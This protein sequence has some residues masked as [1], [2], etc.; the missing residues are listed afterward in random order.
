MRSFSFFVARRY[1][2]SKKSHHAIN[3]ISAISVIGV[4]FATL[5][6]VCTLSV[7]N[8]F[9]ELVASCFTAFDPQLKV[10]PLSGKTVSANDS[11]LLSLRRHPMVDV[12]SES[13][14]EHALIAFGDR[15]MMVMIKGVQDNFKDLTSFEQLLYG[16][17]GFR[18]KDES[19]SRE[20]CILG[21]NLASSLGVSAHPDD[22]MLV[23]A[24]QKGERINMGNPAASFTQRPLYTSGVVFSVQQERYD[25]A[26]VLTSLDFARDLFQEPDGVSA[27]ELRIKPEYDLQ[28]AKE[29]LQRLL[30]DRFLVLDRYE[31]QADIFKVMKVEKLIAYVFLT[32]ILLVACFNIIGSVSMLIIEKKDDV[33]VLRNL[34]ATERMIIRIF[35]FEGR[36]ITAIGALSGI[37]V[38]L[39]LC[40][41]QQTFGWLKLGRSS[42]NFLVDAYPVSVYWGDVLLVFVTVLVVGYLALWYPVRYLSRKYLEN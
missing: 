5:A 41:L 25:D 31:Q 7:F 3:I 22:Q 9:Q 13:L 30:G 32:F 12:Y 38:G 39:L 17:G 6:L 40:Y 34:G 14:E 42:G 27:V 26:Y 4:A 20:L 10:K 23:Y 18:L 1:L 2:F 35:L 11:S 8:G 21:I 16:D 24:P 19:Q 29:E 33:L 28:T 15:Q 36:L 37:L